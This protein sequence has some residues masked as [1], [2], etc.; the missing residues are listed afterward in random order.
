MSVG[1]YSKA[2]Q[3]MELDKLKAKSQ[4]RHDYEER[5]MREFSMRSSAIKPKEKSYDNNKEPNYAK[6]VKE[7][8]GSMDDDSLDLEIEKLLRELDSEP[9]DN[10]VCYEDE[11]A[12]DPKPTTVKTLY[13]SKYDSESAIEAIVRLQK[14]HDILETPRHMNIGGDEYLMVLCRER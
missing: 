7:I 1:H 11:K 6:Q 10:I 9:S 3:I 8:I 2:M 13:C 4:I 14:T 12:P 5:R